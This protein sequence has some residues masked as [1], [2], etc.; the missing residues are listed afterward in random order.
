MFLEFLRPLSSVVA[1][2]ASTDAQLYSGVFLAADVEL[3]SKVVACQFLWSW[4]FGEVGWRA[5]CN[6]AEHSARVCTLCIGLMMVSSELLIMSA[7]LLCHYQMSRDISSIKP[8]VIRELYSIGKASNEN[9]AVVRAAHFTNDA[10]L[11]LLTRPPKFTAV[12]GLPVLST[13]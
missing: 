11:G 4:G 10:I 6:S 9:Q 5:A 7:S 3:S 12:S 8:P 1:D 2:R 13:M